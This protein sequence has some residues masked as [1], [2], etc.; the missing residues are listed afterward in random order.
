MTLKFCFKCNEEFLKQAGIRLKI[1]VLLK[2]EI[3][4]FKFRKKNL[5][6]KYNFTKNCSVP[7]VAVIKQDETAKLVKSVTV[8]GTTGRKI[9]T[10]KVSDIF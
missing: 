6:I 8:D 4:D 5:K 3:F 9:N 2:K 1:A 7:S 10:V